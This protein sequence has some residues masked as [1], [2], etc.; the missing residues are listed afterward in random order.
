MVQP[1]EEKLEGIPQF[2]QRPYFLGMMVATMGAIAFR[3]LVMPWRETSYE[4]QLS[5]DVS[6][7]G[8]V[9]DAGP[10]R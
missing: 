1:L 4:S 2:V 10:G 7:D 5:R 6:G 9:G 8:P 3:A